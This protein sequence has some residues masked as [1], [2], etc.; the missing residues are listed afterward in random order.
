MTARQPDWIPF[1]INKQ[2]SAAV[3]HVFNINAQTKPTATFLSEANFM[4][5]LKTL[6]SSSTIRL[7]IHVVIANEMFAFADLATYPA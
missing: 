7:K 2:C 5:A 6:F 3:E 1:I 4:D